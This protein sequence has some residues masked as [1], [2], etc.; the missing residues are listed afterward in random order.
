MEENI[1]E[2]I[3]L[4]VQKYLNLEGKIT[5]IANDLK[6]DSRLITEKLSTLGYIVRGG[7]SAKQ[8]IALK[9]AVDDYIENIDKNLAVTFYAKKHGCARTTLSNQLKSLGY[10]IINR[11]TSVKFNENVFDSI[12]SEEKAYWLGFIFAD[13]YISN[14]GQFELSLKESDSEHLEKFNKFMECTTPNKVKH[15]TIVTNGKT[16]CRCRWFISNQHLKDV[17]FSLGCVCNKSLILKFPN[18]D[19]FKSKELIRHFIRGY[20][21]GDGSLTWRNKEHTLPDISVL[22]TEH[23]LYSILEY[24]NLPEYKLQSKYKNECKSFSIS[25]RKALDVAKFLYEN[26]NIY[27]NRKYNVYLEYCRLYEESYK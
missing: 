25:C 27:L 15:S 24:L 3:N 10:T 12:N 23:F 17:L 16:Y 11:Q 4:A 5:E 18:T 19:I 26:S 14:T 20:V 1:N 6:I 9:E 7:A 8:V 22:G 13:G 21:D 2:K